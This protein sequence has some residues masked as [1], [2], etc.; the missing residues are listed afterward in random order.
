MDESGRDVDDSG[1]RLWWRRRSRNVG[2]DF[3]VGRGRLFPFESVEKMLALMRY[4]LEITSRSGIS[5]LGIRDCR[6]QIGNRHHLY[7]LYIL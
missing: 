6:I 4:V 1:D 5:V 2:G 7:F 3:G